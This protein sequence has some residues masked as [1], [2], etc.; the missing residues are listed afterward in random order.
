MTLRVQYSITENITYFINMAR[1]TVHFIYDT[2]EGMIRLRSGDTHRASGHIVRTMINSDTPIQI[3][4]EIP[5]IPLELET[6]EH[7][8]EDIAQGNITAEEIERARTRFY[9]EQMQAHQEAAADARHYITNAQFN[10][11]TLTTTTT[12]PY[13]IGA[14]GAGITTA[15]WPTPLTPLNLEEVELKSYFEPDNENES[16]FAKFNKRIVEIQQKAV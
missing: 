13:P 6:E 11:T 5:P 4:N 16:D 7:P 8:Q 2:G 1:N 12:G 14:G 10:N 3:G 9:Y 15:Y